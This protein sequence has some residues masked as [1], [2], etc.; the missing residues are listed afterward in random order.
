MGFKN[1]YTFVKSNT[2]D[3]HPGIS[4]DILLDRKK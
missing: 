3:L 2:K 4:A 1:R